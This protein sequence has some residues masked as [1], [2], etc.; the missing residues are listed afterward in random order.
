MGGYDASTNAMNRRQ[1]SATPNARC[2]RCDEM[3]ARLMH[4]PR[5]SDNPQLRRYVEA[6]V[7]LFHHRPP[8]QLTDEII[9]AIDRAEGK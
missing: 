5:A 6:A 7:L 9:R 2:P 1:L 3:Q 8:T 4:A